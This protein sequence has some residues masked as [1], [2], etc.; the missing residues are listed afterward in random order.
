MKRDLGFFCQVGLLQLICRGMRIRIRMGY[1]QHEEGGLSVLIR[2]KDRVLIMGL[3][4]GFLQI[5]LQI[6]FNYIGFCHVVGPGILL[7]IK[8]NYIGF[9]HVFGPGILLQIKFNYLGFCH[10]FW[11]GILLQIKFKYIGFCHV[12]GPG[13][14]LQIK[15]NYIGC[16]HVFIYSG[17]IKIIYKCIST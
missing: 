10:V 14:L 7:Q 12:F 1:G 5:L 2:L 3:G 15:F 9:C 16:C 8:F 17:Q 4:P 11:P 6:K 13:I